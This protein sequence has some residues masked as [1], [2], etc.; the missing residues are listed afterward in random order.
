MKRLSSSFAALVV[1]APFVMPMP[2]LAQD[3]FALDEI[4]VSALRTAVERLRTGVSVSVVEAEEIEAA[5]DTSLA[6]TLSRLPGVS[7]SSSGPFGNTA[8]LR[9]RGADGRYLAVFVDGIRVSDPTGTTVSFDWGGLTPAGIARI[10][11]LR[12]SQ[13]ALWGGA[14]VGGVV[15]ITTRGALEDG[16]HQTVAVEAGSY[17]TGKL[18]YGLTHKS[19]GTELAF[20]ASALRTD[21]FSAADGGAEDDGARANRLSFSLRHQVSDTLAVGGA[22]FV[23]DLTQ[24]FDGYGPIC[25]PGVPAWITFCLNDIAGNQQS[26]TEIGARAFAELSFG[27]TTHVFEVTQ[28]DV[29]RRYV[30][31]GFASGYDGRRLTLGWQA[32]TETS[33]VLSFVYGL[34]WSRETARYTNLPTGRADT[35]LLGGFA[36][37]LWSPSDRF[38][39]SASL[40]RDVNSG[41]GGFTSG[42]VA[43]AFR[44]SETT[45]L[46]AAYATGFR[47][48]SIDERFGDYG[49]FAG[50]PNLEPEESRSYELG[51][52]QSFGSGASISATLFRLEVDNLVSYRFL[53]PVS[54]LENLP[55]ASVREGV[56]LAATVPLSDRVGLGLA[57]T[58]TDGRRPNGARLTQVPYHMLDLV[59]DAQVTE[60]LAGQVSVK[61]VAGRVDNDANTFT[62]IDMP[63]YTVVNAQVSYDLTD[64]TEAYLKVENLLDTDYQV[65]QGYGTPGRSVFLGIQ[66]K[67]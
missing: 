34:D 29:E 64:R 20:T 51:V 62:P 42:R 53:L 60:R 9:I 66:S 43:L 58:Y 55:G 39:L 54:T 57:Y 40:R 4:V 26:K 65:V 46:R 63:D 19:G 15:N 25:P 3:D 67:F 6:T 12:G 48:P 13:S 37:V 36:Q 30:E 8:N 22:L 61:H 33:E 23:N 17:G 16:T 5:R 47:A 24:D 14:A 35:E 2:V 44:P 45:T 18:T 27:A 31:A 21:G 10:E 50:N 59:I 41:F 32:T 56:E 49:T 38:D 1:A 28:F 11:V 52:E 7:V